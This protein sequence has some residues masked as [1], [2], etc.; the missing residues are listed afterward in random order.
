MDRSRNARAVIHLAALLFLEALLLTFVITF[1]IWF[2]L[3]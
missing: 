1:V 3:G 2:L